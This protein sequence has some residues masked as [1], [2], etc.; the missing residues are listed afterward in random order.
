MHSI[1]PVFPL[2]VT[3]V[4]AVGA[5]GACSSSSSKPAD[6]GTGGAGGAGTGGHDA[7]VSDGATDSAASLTLTS[8]ALSQGGT[9][10]AENTCAGVNTSPP[11]TWSA[12][13]TGTLSYAIS[14]TDLDIS[15]VHWVIWDIP[16]GTT[17]LTAALP[18]DTTLTV[19]PVGAKQIHKIE[20][21][22]AGGAYRG[23]CPSGLTHT[24]QFEVNAIGSATLGGVS[25]T[26]TSEQVKAAVQAASLAH[27]DLSGTSNATAP[28]TDGGG[29]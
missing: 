6:G 4:L 7:A 22:G 1:R 19:P 10:L 8:T 2:V 21:F 27:G 16:A 20:F 14:L 9:F 15:A 29:Q 13:P 12:G 11:L 5:F 18:G 3:L 17:S 24:Y 28:A 23:P 26:S 25:G